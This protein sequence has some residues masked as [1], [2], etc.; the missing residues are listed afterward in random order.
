[1]GRH[2]VTALTYPWL[3]HWAIGGH[4]VALD[5]IATELGRVRSLLQ[6]LDLIQVD[7]DTWHPGAGAETL[8]PRATALAHLF[9]HD[10]PGRE[11]TVE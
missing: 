11:G 8:L 6:A 9:R 10:G 1:M 5:D 3:R 2:L 7:R 4:P